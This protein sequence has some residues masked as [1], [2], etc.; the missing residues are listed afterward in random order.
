M[1]RASAVGG[2]L[3]VA[4]D[5]LSASWWHVVGLVLLL[6]LVARAARVV[7]FSPSPLVLVPHVGHAGAPR[8]TTQ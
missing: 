5:V 2:S 3:L 1:R 4:S 8:F 6:L 7:L